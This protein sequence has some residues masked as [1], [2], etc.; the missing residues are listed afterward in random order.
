MSRGDCAFTCNGCRHVARLV[1]ELGD[2][3]QMMD[4]MMMMITGKGLEEESGEKGEQVAR[5]GETEEKEKCERVMTSGN[6]LTE[7]SREGK[8]TT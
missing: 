4:S 1:G 3:R 8:E 6:S 5:R 7:E 2:I